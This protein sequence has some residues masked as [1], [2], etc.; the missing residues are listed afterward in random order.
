MPNYKNP[1]MSDKDSYLESILT[2]KQLRRLNRKK[3]RSVRGERQIAKEKLDRHERKQ[4]KLEPRT[5]SQAEVIYG[6]ENYDMVLITGPAGVGKS[7]CTTAWAAQQFLKRRISKIVLTRPNEP[8]GRSLG[9]FPGTVD[10]KMEVWLQPIVSVL[11]EVLGPN[12]YQIARDRGQ[13]I[14]QPIETIRGMSFDDSFIIVD[15]AQNLEKDHIKAIVTRI[16]NNSKI[17]FTG[18]LEQSDI[19]GPS[20][21][22]LLLDKVEYNQS[23][24]DEVYIVEFTVEDIVRSRLCRLWVEA[25]QGDH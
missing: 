11:K 15:E 19:R 22:Q 2:P 1:S 10:E 8:T 24:K 7:F 9:L 25:L 14:Y 12:I 23:L 16:G 4:F 18:D 13:I 6:I 21:L 3:S 17:V 20:G 5:Q